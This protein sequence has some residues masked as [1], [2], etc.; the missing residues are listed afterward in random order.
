MRMMFSPEPVNPP[1]GDPGLFVDFNTRRRA[2][3]FDLGDIAALAPRKILRGFAAQAAA[4]AALRR[5]RAG[6]RGRLFASAPPCWTTGFPASASRS[7]RKCTSTVWKCRLA[8]LGLAVGPWL[9]DLKEAALRGVPDDTP[10]AAL[11]AGGAGERVFTL[12]ALKAG[13]LQ[14]I[15]GEKICYVTD[16]AFTP[17]NVERGSAHWPPARRSCSSKRPSWKRTGSTPRARCT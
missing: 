6:R 10:V 17:R 5:R 3:L 12:G 14:F 16:V 4:A 8:E 1:F 11:L 9:K 2:L 13:V 15:P 7:R